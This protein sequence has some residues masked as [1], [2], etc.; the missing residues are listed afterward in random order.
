MKD[1]FVGQW[2]VGSAKTPIC[3]RLSWTFPLVFH[4]ISHVT[5]ITSAPILTRSQI[6]DKLVLLNVLQ[7]FI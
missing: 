1:P 2:S 6:I 3:G 4:S 7:G 5:D